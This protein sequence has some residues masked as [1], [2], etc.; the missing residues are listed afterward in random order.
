MTTSCLK[1]SLWCLIKEGIFMFSS[2]CVDILYA[3]ISIR[4]IKLN[5]LSMY[6]A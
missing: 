3:L 2:L 6:G 4:S 1:V 5:E